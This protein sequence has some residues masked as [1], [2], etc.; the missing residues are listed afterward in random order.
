MQKLSFR[1]IRWWIFFVS[2]LVVT[3]PALFVGMVEVGARGGVT[4]AQNEL[5]R[6]YH[7]GLWFHAKNPEKALYWFAK[8]S[9]AD[10]AQLQYDTGRYLQE[11]GEYEEAALWYTLSAIQNYAPAQYELA[12]LFDEGLW[13]KQEPQSAFILF[14]K[15]ASQG[16]EQAQYSL[17]MAY[18]RGKGVHTDPVKAAYWIK[19][20]ADQGY[21]HAQISLAF[22]YANGRGVKQDYKL[23]QEWVRKAEEN[24][25]IAADKLEIP[26]KNMEILVNNIRW[27][28]GGRVKLIAQ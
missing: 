17:G 5:G 9:N 6:W 23:T 12:K 15:A 10:D 4:Y 14:E 19:K 25:K 28:A 24:R 7:A 2:L 13:D 1:K 20:S 27:A 18:A 3:L 8:A 16:H 22:L 26:V 11:Q 21:Y